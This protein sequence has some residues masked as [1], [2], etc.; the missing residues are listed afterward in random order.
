MVIECIRQ[1]GSDQIF[2]V[3]LYGILSDLPQGSLQLFPLYLCI[4]IRTFEFAIDCSEEM[5]KFDMSK[6]QL[7][8][9]TAFFQ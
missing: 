8:Q 9:L 5:N 6:S 3:F 4:D 7:Q 1:S 2:R